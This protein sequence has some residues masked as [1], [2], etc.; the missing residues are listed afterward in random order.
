[1]K[2][3]L[4]CGCSFVYGIGLPLHKQDPD[5]FCNILSATNKNLIGKEQINISVGGNS[6]ESIFID[7]AREILTGEYEYVFVCWTSYPRYIFYTTASTDIEQVLPINPWASNRVYSNEFR[8]RLLTLNHASI[9]NRN[10]LVFANTL[11]AIA[12]SNNTKVFFINMFLPYGAIDATSMSAYPWLNT[13]TF[14]QSR[15]DLGNDGAHPGPLT[16]QLFAQVLT[17]KLNEYIA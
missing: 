5:L 1:M 14:L 13:T 7:S 4:F 17:N 8:D 16:H 3:V 15:I 11:L 10:L 9:N 12:K 6:N 2:K